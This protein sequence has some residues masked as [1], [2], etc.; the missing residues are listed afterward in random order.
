MPEEPGKSGKA[1][2]A[3][4]HSVTAGS[5]EA[6]SGGVPEETAE[7]AKVKKSPQK[8]TILTN[9][10]AAAM[11]STDPELKK[12]KKKKRKIGNDTEPGG[13]FAFRIGHSDS[14]SALGHVPLLCV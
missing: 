2:K 1:K 12:K 11:S 4:K 10:E 3:L 8:L 14:F 9:G 13:F 5:A 7:N 6:Q